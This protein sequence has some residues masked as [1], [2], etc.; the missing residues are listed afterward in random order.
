M[1]KSDPIERAL[2]RLGELRHAEVSTA[3]AEEVRGFLRDRS[4]LVVAKPRRLRVS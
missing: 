1:G 3:V 4:N 2:D